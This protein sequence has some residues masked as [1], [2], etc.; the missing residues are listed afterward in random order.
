MKF[1]AVLAVKDEAELVD[2][3]IDH[4]RAI[5]VDLIVA[6]DMNSTDGTLELLQARRS[7]DSFWLI[8]GNDADAEARG[9]FTAASE[10][11]VKIAEANYDWLLFLDA[12][13][14]WIPASGQLRDCICLAEADVLSVPRFNIPLVEGSQWN[15]IEFDPCHYEDLLVIFK[16]IPDFRAFL[17]GDPETPWIRGVP[18]PKVMARP[19]YVGGVTMG[20]HDIIAAG[21]LPPRRGT[22][23]DLFI[24]HLPFTTKTRF[25]RKIA[26]IR[27][28]F[29]LHDQFLGKDQAWHWRRWMEIVDRE[30]LDREFDRNVFGLETCGELRRQGIIRSAKDI[31]LAKMVSS[32]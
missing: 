16:P 2:R 29:A 8:L 26:N 10:A 3:A 17:G 25:A 15:S 12:D 9:W 19:T 20:A 23:F 30:G 4:L 1:A 7:D 6:C 27:K 22:P 5:G 31:F 21:D 32:K 13:E 28:A 11:A 24:A 14:F 18:V